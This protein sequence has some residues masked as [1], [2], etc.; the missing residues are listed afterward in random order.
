MKSERKENVMEEKT[1]NAKCDYVLFDEN[2]DR[3]ALI[4]VEADHSISH[5]VKY[6]GEQK[7]DGKK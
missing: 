4:E 2:Q 1:M 6:A 5:L 7:K 3:K